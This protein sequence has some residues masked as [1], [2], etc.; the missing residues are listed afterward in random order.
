MHARNWVQLFSFSEGLDG[1][2]SKRFKNNFTFRLKSWL[3]MFQVR[4]ATEWF[5]R[6][7]YCNVE[8]KWQ[9]YH[10]ITFPG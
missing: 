2:T 7:L 3:E 9:N 10:I 1:Q 5:E 6:L 8:S 4:I